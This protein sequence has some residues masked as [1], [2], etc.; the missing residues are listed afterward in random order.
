MAACSGSSARDRSKLA[1]STAFRAQKRPSPS[2][3]SCTGFIDVQ[4][5][6]VQVDDLDCSMTSAAY[7]MQKVTLMT[8]MSCGAHNMRHGIAQKPVCTEVVK[9]RRCAGLKKASKAEHAAAMD[10]YEAWKQLLTDKNIVSGDCLP[11]GRHYI[12]PTDV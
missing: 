2:R 4:P 3:L 8:H 10:E 1:L 11:G 12:A 7:D 6:R 5:C 9:E